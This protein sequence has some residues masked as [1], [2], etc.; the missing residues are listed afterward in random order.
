VIMLHRLGGEL[1]G[2]WLLWRPL[3]AGLGMG[4]CCWVSKDL[5]FASAAFGV[6]SGFL[7]YA[8]LLLLLQTFTP[9]ERALLQGAMRFKLGSVGQ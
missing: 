1:S 7:V 2:L 3:V 6:I 9:Q 8:G 4:F 5:G